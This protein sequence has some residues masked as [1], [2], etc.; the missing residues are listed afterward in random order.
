MTTFK[1]LRKMDFLKGDIEEFLYIHDFR[2]W[3]R[4]S[5][6]LWYVNRETG[7]AIYLSKI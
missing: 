4:D 1:Q 3:R 6:G 7:L 5:E 2:F